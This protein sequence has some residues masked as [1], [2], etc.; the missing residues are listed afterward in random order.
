MRKTNTQIIE[1]CESWWSEMADAARPGQQRYSGQLLRLLGWDPPIPFSPKENSSR[2]GAQ[3]YLLRSG[4]QT[5]VAAYFLM[6]GAL[7]SPGSLVER[8][9]DFCKT[10]RLLLNEAQ[11]LNVHY[12]FAT[13]LYRSYLYDVLTDELVLH[14][15]TPA[16]FNEHM[17]P[18]LRREEME[19]GA[20][21]E[22][23][24]Q[25]RSAMAAQLRDWMKYW[26]T[27]YV[28][29][30]GLTEARAA[31]VMDRL[32]VTRYLFAKD[33]LRRTRWRLEQRFLSLLDRAA[34]HRP[35]GVGRE[36]SRLFND[37]GQDWG[38]DLFE[39]DPYIE[40]A[41][42]N[43]VLTAG[44]LTEFGLM[45]RARFSI[46]TIIESFNE[47]DPGEKMRVRM[48]PQ[49]NE[50][51]DRYLSRQTLR[52]VD[53]ARVRID[54]A[55]EGYRAIF[56]WFDKVIALYDRLDMDF[57]AKARQEGREPGGDLFEWSQHDASRPGA[58]GD[59]IA[60]ACERGVEVYFENARQHRVAQL[61]L[62]LHLISRYHQLRRPVDRLP[63]LKRVLQP[64][65]RELAMNPFM[66]D[67]REMGGDTDAPM[68]RAA[69]A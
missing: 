44:L 27:Q 48:V 18:V 36:L 61:L 58:C 28:K 14:A 20:L 52:T 19:R 21:E 47:G 5:S 65:P 15:D 4:G 38:I 32:L 66:P 67:T 51:R 69:Q 40:D 62:T 68:L 60:Y 55:E 10:T 33:V 37:M 8:G 13:D 23:R 29:A 22:L 35:E 1:L 46:A 63:S 30:A 11:T 41:L 53:D 57:E 2:L 56:H 7:E 12:M 39:N 45:S 34:S 9:L 16:E 54:L 59:K 43:D 31:V 49:P 17:V 25:P 26:S 6:P 3:P 42:A 24:R 50:E 64:R